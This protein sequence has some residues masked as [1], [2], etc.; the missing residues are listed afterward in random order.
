MVGT[1]AGRKTS[2]KMGT[3]MTKVVALGYQA[4]VEVAAELA[5]AQTE[6]GLSVAAVETIEGSSHITMAKNLVEAPINP[7]SNNGI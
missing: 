5:A 2:T 4:G 1:V 6:Q 7:V 3:A